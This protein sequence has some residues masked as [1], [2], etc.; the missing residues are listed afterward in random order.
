MDFEA[1]IDRVLHAID[2]FFEHLHEHVRESINN[3]QTI[4]SDI[5]S[6]ARKF[7]TLTE[8]KY[9]CGYFGILNASQVE[10]PKLRAHRLYLIDK[11]KEELNVLNECLRLYLMEFV[12]RLKCEMYS[13]QIQSL[14]DV[15]LLNFNYTYTY[16]KVYGDLRRSH[17][18]IHGDCLYGGMVL[19]VSDDSFNNQLEYIYFVKYF[20][21][22]QKKTGSFYKEW[23]RKP[24]HSEQTWSDVSC[25]VYIIGHSMADTD[26]GVLED[27]FRND[28]VE[29]ITIFYHDQ[30][31][32]ENIVINLVSMFGKEFVIEQTGVERI[33][34]EQLTP[35]VEVDRC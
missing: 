28:W 30:S 17:H 29:K 34:F 10:A 35:A 11:L 22:I 6:I 9:D 23:I 7:L 13:E 12:E 24:N 18:P 3:S 14:E 21:R 19:G 27:F 15:N 20:Q 16:K 32:Y 5:R 8:D 26:K 33:V 1:E 25:E 31:A 2:F 4:T